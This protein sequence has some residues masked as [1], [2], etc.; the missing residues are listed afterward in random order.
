MEINTISWLG[1]LSQKDKVLLVNPPVQEV[2][3]AWLKWNQPLDLLLLSSKLREE[4][5]CSVEILDFMLP[6]EN[7]R[8]TAK[9]YKQK[10]IKNT[11]YK[12]RLYGTP[13]EQISQR[14]DLVSSSW[15]PTHIVITSLTSYWYEPVLR[16]LPYFRTTFP[17][18]SISLIGAFPA[19]ETNEALKTGAD[20][21]VKG[22]FASKHYLPNYKIYKSNISSILNDKKDINFGAVRFNNENKVE[23]LYKQIIS[24]QESNIKDIV[25]YDED[26]LKNAQEE[27]LDVF[28][29]LDKK[30]INVNFHGIC[31]LQPANAK[32]DIYHRMLKGG[33]RSFFF[34]YELESNELNLDSYK[35]IYYDLIEYNSI[36]KIPSGSLAGFLM[37]GTPDDDLEKMFKHSFNILETCTSLIPKPF[38]PR[39]GSEQYKKITA[40]LGVDY[41]S[42][43]LFPMADT[44]GITRSEYKDFYQHAAFLN[45]KRNGN[46]FN[47]FDGSYTS[48]SLRKSLGKKVGT[49]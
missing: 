37:I 31:G 29:L 33:F 18:V 42:P 8:V 19:I 47:Y 14:L 25:I 11:S 43:H 1:K 40:E 3:Y 28:E 49:I 12:T 34:E 24:L 13:L 4:I 30:N 20:F 15:K 48:A 23:N 35:K 6:D 38:T 44:N 41:L 2:R 32:G 10:T 21:V 45:E 5:G 26:I 9:E 39:L 17:D 27:L 46:S 16:L 36:R 7:G 22:E